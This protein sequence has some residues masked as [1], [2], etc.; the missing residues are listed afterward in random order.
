MGKLD[1]ISAAIG[2]LRKG[3][4]SVEGRMAGVEK[5]MDRREQLQD[6]R[7]AQNQASISGLKEEL[8]AAITNGHS[9]EPAT[10]TIRQKVALASIGI[11][12]LSAVAW[13]IETLF[14]VFLTHIVGHFWKS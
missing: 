7:H 5:R 9:V 2:E 8:K 14:G 10:L 12:I 13:L 4:T 11:A 6:E 3:M 1:E